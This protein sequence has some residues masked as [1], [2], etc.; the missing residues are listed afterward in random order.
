MFLKLVE[1]QDLPSLRGALN[2]KVGTWIKPKAP[3]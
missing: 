3:R 2:M 1:R